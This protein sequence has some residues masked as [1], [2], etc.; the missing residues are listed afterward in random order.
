MNISR[1]A[2]SLTDED[3][4]IMRKEQRKRNVNNILKNLEKLKNKPTIKEVLGHKFYEYSE[5][6]GVD[7]LDAMTILEASRVYM[8]TGSIPKD[9]ESL[10]KTYRCL[11][12]YE[13]IF[14]PARKKTTKSQPA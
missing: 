1:L 11:L 7:F 13:Q 8:A 9:A 14:K 4:D 2:E 6:S 5:R 10:E 12:R 3:L